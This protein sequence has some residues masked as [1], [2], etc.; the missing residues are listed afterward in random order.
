MK[1][2]VTLA[3]FLSLVATA[4]V[5]AQEVPSCRVSQSTLNAPSSPTVQQGPIQVGDAVETR[6]DSPHPYAG[7]S[8]TKPQLVYSREIHHP[9]AS[10]VSPHFSRFELAAGDY[11]IVRSPDFSRSWRY[12]GYGKKNRGKKGN[13]GFWGIHISGETA[14]VELWAKG[15]VGDYGFTI[16]YYGRGFPAAAM[17]LEESDTEAVCTT[18]DKE[19]AVCYKNSEPAMYDEAKAV[20]RLFIRKGLSTFACTG[21][22]LGDEGHMMTNQ[23]CIENQT[24]ANDTDYEFMSEGAT[25]GTDCGDWG[26]CPGT[27]EA[28]DGTRI[29]VN[30]NLDFALVKLPGNLSATYG[31]LQLRETGAVL[32]ERIYSPQHPAGRAKELAVLSTYPENPSG[33]AEVDS[34]TEV[35]CSD[36]AIDDVG[37]FMDTEGGSSGSPVLGYSDNLVVALHH[38]QGNTG[39]ASGTGSDTPNRGAPIPQIIT[40]LGANLPNNAVGSGEEIFA[41]GFESGDVSAWSA[42]KP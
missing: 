9:G 1:R 41:D 18:D 8:S 34:L 4:G 35:G 3:V 37:Y 39:C 2:L 23:H 11:V 7:L 20:V 12:E 26:G 30:E 15:P 29:Q 5:A 21:W 33:F 10:F 14:I 36:A 24:H 22:L 38:C 19:N 17:G 6:I 25:C 42:S 13:G 28:M 31:F 16:D 40:A 27:I 32:E